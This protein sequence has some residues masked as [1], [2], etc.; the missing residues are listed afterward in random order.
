MTQASACQTPGQ[1]RGR[2]PCATSITSNR[3]ASPAR[4]GRASRNACA[5]RPIRRRCRGE[6]DP[7]AS[8]TRP[9][10]LTSMIASTLPRRARMSISPAGQRQRRATTR[11]PRSRK[12]QQQSHSASR[13]RRCARRPRTTLR[14]SVRFTCPFRWRGRDDRARAGRARFRRQASPPPRAR[15]IRRP[16]RAAAPR[17]RDGRASRARAARRR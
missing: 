8:A 2:Q 10:A 11:Q 15:R 4:S 16:L 1:W 13:P 3:G 12:C 14:G 17:C 7:A 9:R 6:I 5:A